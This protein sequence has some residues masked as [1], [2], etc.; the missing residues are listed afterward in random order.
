MKYYMFTHLLFLLCC[1]LIY[2]SIELFNEILQLHFFPRIYCLDFIL[3]GS[4]SFLFLTSCST[5]LFLHRWN[6]SMSEKSRGRS[7][8]VWRHLAEGEQRNRFWTC[9]VLTCFR[10]YFWLNFLLNFNQG[11]SGFPHTLKSLNFLEL[12]FLLLWHMIRFL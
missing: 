12:Y 4:L 2:L 8:T 11:N 5:L 1:A 7:R 9:F 3:M 6:R 10:D